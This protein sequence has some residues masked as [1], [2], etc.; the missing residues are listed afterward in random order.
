MNKLKRIYFIMLFLA[1]CGFLNAQHTID[2]PV[3]MGT[4]SYDFTYKW[5]DLSP[6]NISV[7]NK[8]NLQSVS[9]Y[10]F[11]YFKFQITREMNVNINLLFIGNAGGVF[12]IYDANKKEIYRYSQENVTNN[13]EGT[14][15]LDAGTYYIGLEV[16]GNMMTYSLQVNGKTTSKE[17]SNILYSYD[18]D[19]NRIKREIILAKL[20]STLIQPEILQDKVAE[21]N[22]KIYPNPTYGQL[23][24]EFDKVDD[25]K[26]CTIT[27]NSMNT[28]EQIL[29][30]KGVFPVTDIDISN[31]PFGIYTMLIDI[32]GEYTSWKILKK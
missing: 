13:P 2:S 24:V 32:D 8:I 7:S 27:I 21:R 28:G 29:R 22:I 20:S 23:S 6:T 19:G 5:P 3:D 30:K 31:Q 26:N 18:A 4:F 10:K 16:A 14:Y 17:N 1:L 15:C 25:I 12:V 11:A 9:Y